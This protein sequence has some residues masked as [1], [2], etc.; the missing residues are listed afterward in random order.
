MCGR[1]Q[2]L[3]KEKVALKERQVVIEGEIKAAVEQEIP[4][5]QDQKRISSDFEAAK[6]RLEAEDGG[7]VVWWH[8]SLEEVWAGAVGDLVCASVPRAAER[9]KA[10][11]E[12]NTRFHGFDDLERRVRDMEREGLRRQLDDHE[13]EQ[14]ANERNIRGELERLSTFEAQVAE[15]NK[16]AQDKHRLRRETEVR[17]LSW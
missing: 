15:M 3:E 7:C 9:Q 10:Q 8:Q 17:E 16:T 6:K 11:V 2:E 5:K 12:C 13:K 4:L 1:T 14:V